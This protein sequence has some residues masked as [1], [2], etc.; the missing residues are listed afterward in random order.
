VLTAETRAR[1]EGHEHAPGE[2]RDD[3]GH[4]QETTPAPASTDTAA[5]HVDPPGTPAHEH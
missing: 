5:D 3:D 4:S 1:S 2:G